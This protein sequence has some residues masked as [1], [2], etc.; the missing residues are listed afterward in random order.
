MITTTHRIA[1][2]VFRTRADVRIPHFGRDPYTWFSANAGHRPDVSNRF[3][4]VDESLLT[5]SP[6]A[7]TE[8][9]LFLPY[10][11]NT[12][13]NLEC[14]LLRAPA[15]RTALQDCLEHP[16]Y[17][18]ARIDRYWV[19]IRDFARKEFTLFHTPKHHTP[20]L[21]WYPSELQIS[22]NLREIF[23]TFLSCFS[24]ILLH[25][26]GVIRR[27]KAAVLFAP[28]AG[29]KT[30][31]ATRLSTKVPIL[32]D[33]QIILKK[34][35]ADV[36]AHSTPLGRNTSGLCQARVGGLFFLEKA[37]HFELIPVAPS[38]FVQCLWGGNLRYT[39]FLPK[40]LKINAFGFF[41][42]AC[43][44]APTYVMRF[45]RDYVDWNAIDTAMR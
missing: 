8:S 32:Q 18:D 45:P 19:T 10:T 34:E 25:G 7:G 23:S 3:F 16:D 21:G 43:H 38:E 33:D 44:Q 12:P 35:G 39:H 1:E 22:A 4:R 15:V 11:H 6:L 31:V 37:Q 26:A 17:L 40:A 29:G 30:T 5:L 27:D 2:I 42:D 36:I 41:C 28:D 14:I 20:D 9:D 24:A 13:E